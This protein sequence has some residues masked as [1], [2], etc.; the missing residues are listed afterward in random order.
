[1]KD[2][3]NIL[4]IRMSS[5]GDII[6]V[7]PTI[8]AL[9]ENYPEAN[10]VWAVHE[11]FAD[12][13]PGKPW[14]DEVVYV[15]RKRLKNPLYWLELRK[16]LHQYKF[17]MCLDLQ[18]F[19]KSAI[20]A[21]LSGA[22][23]KY[24]HW[25]VREFSRLTSKPLVGPNQYGHVIQRYLDTVRMLGGKV[26]DILFPI[27]DCSGE[28]AKIKERLASAGIHGDYV[29]LAPGTRWSAKDWPVEKFGE[30]A[31][32]IARTGMPI[33]LVGTKADT[34]KAKTISDMVSEGNVLN[35]CGKTSI[36]ELMA[37][38]KN[39]RLFIA[40]DTGPLYMASVFRVPLIGL[41]GPTCVE[42]FFPFWYDE[43]E[44][45]VSSTS[46]ATQE[47]YIF[48]DYDCMKYISVNQVWESYEKLMYKRDAHD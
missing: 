38:L 12:V 30:L 34:D 29:I 41:Y 21:W 2:Y 39:S 3:K 18:G 19:T 15:D 37:V 36:R 8:A 28:E 6:H 17:D 13:L 22:K 26:S 31:Q 47:R 25:E 16:E 48:H 33:V 27:P 4:V 11:N 32:R 9:R 40:G 7:L 45:V 46:K 10:I 24:G 23:E 44:A 1:M 35:L 43:L 42:R 5:L 20:V 14:I